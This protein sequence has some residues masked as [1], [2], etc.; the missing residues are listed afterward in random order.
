M[1]QF[2]GTEAPVVRFALI[3]RRLDVALLVAWRQV[4]PWC[5]GWIVT[6]AVIFAGI[7]AVDHPL[8]LLIRDRTEPMKA[9]ALLVHLPEGIAGI[10]IIGAAALG[11]AAMSRRS[12][13]EGPR[14]GD[15]ASS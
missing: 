12:L 1:E 9:A 7:L 14:A 15:R 11:V 8:T 6:S 3:S 2:R 5:V 10:T 13:G 4:W